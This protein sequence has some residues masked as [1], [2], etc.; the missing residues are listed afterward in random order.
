MKNKTKILLMI[1]LLGLYGC[2]TRIDVPIDDS[3]VV[4][5]SDA[6]NAQL[7]ELQHWQINGKIAFIKAQERQSATLFWQHDREKNTE[8]LNLSTIFGINILQL[9][10]KEDY[11]T[12]KVDGKS[13]QT[14]DLDQL[15]YSLTGLALPTRAM[16]HWLK[17]LAFLPNDHVQYNEKTQ[18]PDSLTSSYNNKL[19]QISYKKYHQIGHYQLAK[20][21][22]ITQGDLRIKLVVHSWTI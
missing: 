18:L 8:S 11:F 10:S 20:Q 6:R 1:S 16:N 17:G 9:E 4:Q 12:L 2:S 14:S 7:N 15:I 3:F 13:Y 19:W 5:G 22:L 21:F